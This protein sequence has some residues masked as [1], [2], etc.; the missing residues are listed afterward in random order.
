MTY[1]SN[2]IKRQSKGLYKALALLLCFATLIT[3]VHFGIVAIIAK[4]A[5]G[6]HSIQFGGKNIDSI[7]LPQDDKRTVSVEEQADTAYSWQ[8]CID[9][10]NDEWVT[11]SGQK[12]NFLTLSYAMVGSLSDSHGTAY[13]RSVMKSGGNTS[14]SSPV[15]INVSYTAPEAAGQSETVTV[16]N[17]LKS[18]SLIRR[19][20]AA[21][22]DFK[23]H[24]VTV[25]YVY[26]NGDLVS[27]PYVANIADG[28]QFS[29]IVHFPS[30]VGYLAYFGNNTDSS[31]EYEINIDKVTQDVTY[32][33][34]YKPTL[35]SY[36]VHHYVQNILDD[37]Y[38][39]NSTTT[40]QGLTASS[41]GEKC[42]IDIDGFTVL[43][44]DKDVKIAADGSTEIDI[45]YDRNYYLLS[46]DLGGGYGVEPI[47]TRYGA[48]V[49]VSNPTRPGYLFDGWELIE[50]GGATAT[51]TQKTQYN[52]NNGNVTLPSMNLKYRAKWK[53]ANTTFTVVYWTENADDDGY[54]YNSK[55]TVNA[56]SGTVVNG[57]DYNKTIK[58][59]TYNAD[60]TDK[61]IIVEGDG[62][63]VVNVYYTRN[64]Y[65]LTFSGV[66]DG[67][68]LC[69][70]KEHTHT[71]D[72]TYTTGWGK[73]KKTYYCGGCYPPATKYSSWTGK[74]TA[75]GAVKGEETCGQEEHTHNDSCYSSTDDYSV[76]AKYDSKISYVWENEPFSTTYSGRAWECTETSKYSSAL[77]T[78]DRMPGFDATF[79]LYNQS[80]KTKKTIYYYVQKVGTS[81]SE[82]AWPS[83]NENFALLKQVNTYFNYATYD[84]E[85]H[86]IKGF[87]RYTASV[88]G[89]SNNRK[90]F[91]NN[92]LTLYY[93]RKSY[94]LSFYNLKAEVSDKSG[95]VQYE[96]PLKGYYFVPDY[97]ESLEPNAYEFA[98]WFTTPECFD[99]T[100]VNFSTAVMPDSDVT[101]YAKWA[102][103]TH[104]VRVFKTADMTD[105]IDTQTV[106]HGHYAKAPTEISNGNYV[107]N[108][109]FYMDGTEKKAFD[110]NNIP[111][112]RSLDIFAEWSSK[113][114]V[115]YTVRYALE[116]GTEI[117]E[118]TVGSTLAGTS[119]TFTAK[120]G[121]ELYDG[122]REGFFP[123]TNSHTILMNID[124]GN[125]Y[126]FIYTQKESVPYTVRYLEK[127][128]E[129]VL[130]DEKTV[131]D[132]RMSVVTEV[133]K[134]I[135]DFMPDAYQ[136]R[137]V[138]SADGTENVL[139][140]WYTKDE[141]H[142]YYI[143]THW[144]QNLAGDGYTEYRTIQGPETLNKTI[145]ETPLSITGYTYN[146]SKSTASDVLTADGLEL[147]LYY[148]RNLYGY[149][150]KYL[151]YGTNKKLEE[152]SVFDADNRYGTVVSADAAD[153]RGYTV[154]GEKTK[155]R[156]I[157]DKSNEIIFY[158]SEQEVTIKYVPIGLG[159][160]SIGSETVKAATG[161]VSGSVPTPAS[162]YRFDGW[163]ADE[164]CTTPV[165]D[166][167]VG[168]NQKLTPQ[169][170][171]GLFGSATYYAK[172]SK[173]TASLT[174]Q[175]DGW[176]TADENQT[177][178]F[179][180]VGTDE[181][182]KS[183]D[184]TVTVHENGKT[185]ITDL[186]I[187]NYTVTEK[188]DWS[189]RYTPDE[190]STTVSLPADGMTIDYKNTRSEQKWLDGDS[191]KNNI[192]N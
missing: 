110:F 174:I 184:L 42:A 28:E 21:S 116:D 8:L 171:D 95:T 1:G 145:T 144:V 183:I 125:E 27:D 66:R 16:K 98:G 82:T 180:I 93:L 155:T 100:E 149:T 6:S 43:Y 58:H 39:L 182:T 185:T 19:A 113:T 168:E 133:F 41:V 170:A 176:D 169:Q 101:L 88:S 32:T 40:R 106:S 127:G 130:A 84:E 104:T 115:L 142:A 4:A 17:S 123:N 156:T 34:T 51:D 153:I 56:E 90:N 69:G 187:G 114:A 35:V 14:I 52:L 44:Y 70:K 121:T 129:N 50:C 86:T 112:N 73:N 159:S 38:V 120:G 162:G 64:K 158:Y 136:K 76:T 167:W 151:E 57:S 22:S 24:T 132:N 122:Y 89:F 26:A 63:T 128:T 78:I 5:E 150:V 134:Q 179:R 119:K 175:K 138:L 65:T 97:P 140:F 80:S 85:Y 161:S 20:N 139:T 61:D 178:L 83:S 33:V 148:D 67:D 79:T 111:V 190:Q 13:L 173:N 117:A 75:G 107:F 10:S 30:V 36:K 126:T 62:S 81:V 2:K 131:T 23:S 74:P 135:P 91:S 7:V 37:N 118:P 147:N 160:V 157:S 47:Y 109:W 54:S 105:P 77:Q 99:G 94:N 55:E 108:G 46:F 164:G 177:Y 12:R 71:Y 143:I 29:T 49:S 141:T 172:F 166:P 102:P 154:V 15:C 96:A 31:T 189:W 92:T 68:I 59:F 3:S 11:V 124:G 53:T 103:K 60:K 186:P 72:E 152:P 45:Y 87:D 165:S 9:K 146:S 137:L 18:K 192:F 181:D 191:Y 48:T 188:S 25:K 163:F